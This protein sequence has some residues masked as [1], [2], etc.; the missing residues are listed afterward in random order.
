MG[1]CFDLMTFGRFG[2]QELGFFPVLNCSYSEVSERL[3][4][5]QE[6]NWRFLLDQLASVV[7][8]HGY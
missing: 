1:R 7:A 3:R 6:S 5:M 4:N 2:V 8:G